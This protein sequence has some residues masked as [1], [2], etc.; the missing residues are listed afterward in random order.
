[1]VAIPLTF[2]GVSM[3]MEV[4]WINLNFISSYKDYYG[5]GFGN[6]KCVHKHT[7]ERGL[8]DSFSSLS[9]N[10][11]TVWDI[12]DHSKK[13]LKYLQ[14]SYPCEY[15]C[16][17]I[18]H[19]ITDQIT[20]MLLTM[21]FLRWWGI[22]SQQSFISPYYQPWMPLMSRLYERAKNLHVKHEKLEGV[23]DAPLCV[24]H[25]LINGK[26]HDL[27]SCKW[28]ISYVQRMSSWML[29]WVNSKSKLIDVVINKV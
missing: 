24:I 21:M 8:I 27:F 13:Q 10:R 28:F 12:V 5:S 3:K 19:S 17:T 22:L 9:M 15:D 4:R 25:G 1:M 2:M 23:M 29:A 6:R 18:V 20:S 11:W 26:L 7:L 14:I 16:S